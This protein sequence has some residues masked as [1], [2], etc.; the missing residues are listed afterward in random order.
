MFKKYRPPLVVKGLY[1]LIFFAFFIFPSSFFSSIQAADSSQTIIVSAEGL[2]DPNAKTYQKDKGLL[3]DALRKDAQQRIVEKAVG[4]YV[5]SSTLVENY[6]L[7]HDRILT[8]TKGLIKQVIKESNPWIGEDGF[9]HLLMKAEVYVSS[10]QQALKKMS[11]TE[12]IYLIK[13]H[14]NPKI[15][16]AIFIQDKRSDIAENVLKE[17]LKSFGY[18][19]WSEKISQKLKI[20]LAERSHLENFPESTISIS[21]SKSSDFTILGRTRFKTLSHTLQ[22]SN[23]TITKHALTSWTVSCVNN[24]TGEEIYFNTKVPRGKSWSSKSAAI[25]DIGRLMG[26]EFSQDFF[27]QHLH[28]PTEIYQLQ[29]LGLPN[30]DIGTMFKKEFLG[31]RPIINVDFRSFDES[32]LS[33]YEI[34]FAGGRG[35][36]NQIVNDTIIKPLNQKLEENCFKLVSTHGNKV[37]VTFKTMY[38]PQ[39][40]LAKIKSAPPASLAQA[41]PQRLKELIKSEESL[42]KVKEINPQTVAKLESQNKFDFIKNSDKEIKNF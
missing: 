8:R 37:R 27:S 29:V 30:Y 25:Q 28:K 26:R 13:K 39:T 42:K 6:E 1:A 12:R 40:L 4:L 33:L 23:I 34:E 22:P 10:V 18:R 7:V 41:S 16:V 11:R 20:Q 32:G 15:S 3:L 36:F 38:D 14:G 31:L 21:Q 35:N 17:R 19:V 24:H 5:E 2:A 9:A